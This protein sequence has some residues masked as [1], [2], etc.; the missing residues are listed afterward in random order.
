LRNSWAWQEAIAYAAWLTG[1][2]GQAWWL[3]SEAEWEKAARGTDGR[4]YPWGDQFDV[5]RCNTKESNSG[6][7]TPVGRYPTGASPYG[8]LDMTGNVHEWTSSIE[9]PYPYSATDGRERADSTEIRVLRGGC[10]KYDGR[11]ARAALRVGGVEGLVYLLASGF[12]LARA[13]PS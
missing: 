10:W 2:T 9:K 12:R 5:S 11:L 4:I 13:V 1:Q 8:P 7:S 6:D 3:P